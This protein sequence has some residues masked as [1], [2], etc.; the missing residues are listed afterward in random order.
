MK[1]RKWSAAALIWL[2]PACGGRAAQPATVA[3]A[4]RVV[5]AQ[6]PFHWR[7]RVAEGGEIDV[8]V[9]HGSVRATASR[10]DEAEVDARN[11]ACI[12]HMHR[13]ERRVRVTA[14]SGEVDLVVRVPSGVRLVV[15]AVNGP[16]SASEIRDVDAHVVNGGIEIVHASRVR[17]RSVNGAIKATLDWSHAGPSVGGSSRAGPSAGDSSRA[18]RSAADAPD[19]SVLSTVNGDI[20]VS[21]PAGSDVDVDARSTTGQIALGVPVAGYIGAKR[22]HG[23]I[24]HG[25]AVLRLKSVSGAIS[26]GTPK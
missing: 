10:G 14:A 21:L 3:R 7:G 26:V 8:H 16:V 25:G 22:V 11:G 13:D 1:T 20:D 18:E 17:A 6:E 9:V 2:V 5:E 24:G 4:P 15:H 12:V 23:T 19:A